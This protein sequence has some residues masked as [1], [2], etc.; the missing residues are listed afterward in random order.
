V[1]LHAEPRR[2]DVLDAKTPTGIREVPLSPELADVLTVYLDVR[3][4]EA[5]PA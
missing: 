3:R 2:L 4:R 1:R 5:A